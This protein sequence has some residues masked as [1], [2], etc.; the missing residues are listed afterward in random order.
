MRAWLQFL[1]F[2]RRELLQ[3]LLEHIGLV[4]ASTLIAAAIALPLGIWATRSRA[5][6]RWGI[7]TA[8]IV[9]TIPSLAMFG[10]L[11]PLPL[12]GGVGASSAIVALVLY[13]LL[14][15]MRGVYSGIAQVDPAV[16]EAAVALGL[17]ARQRLWQVELP[18]ALPSIFGGLRVAAVI[19]VGTATIGAAIGAG[20]LG[21]FIFR[22]LATAD[23]NLI[24]A[25]AVP[26]ALLALAV[27]GLL[28]GLESMLARRY[29]PAAP[30]PAL[31]ETASGA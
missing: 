2:H 22:G 24:L 27:D 21:E 12:L 18:L 23:N 1:I 13:S 10:F 4:A 25:G 31:A 28:G 9:Q 15:I 14:P 19:A 26:A 6:R 5:A 7:G 17:T 3:L 20:G 30:P 29:R 16:K 11:L 8:N